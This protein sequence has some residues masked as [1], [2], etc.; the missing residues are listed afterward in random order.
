MYYFDLLINYNCVHEPRMSKSTHTKMGVIITNV[1]HAIN[2]T[3]WLYF[4]NDVTRII[5]KDLL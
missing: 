3:G 4:M 1:K 2:D 5:I